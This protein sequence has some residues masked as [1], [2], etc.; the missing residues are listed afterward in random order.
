M[1]VIILKHPSYRSWI[2]HVPSL[3]TAVG[4][5][6]HQRRVRLCWIWWLVCWGWK[7]WF[8]NVFSCLIKFRWRVNQNL[9]IPTP[10]YVNRHD[11]YKFI[12]IYV[13]MIIYESNVFMCI[14]NYLYIFIS[15][16]VFIYRY[17]YIYVVSN[18]SHSY[19]HP[20][21]SNIFCVVL[22]V[23][24]LKQVPFWIF[25]GIFLRA[26]WRQ[27]HVLQRSRWFV[28]RKAVF[29]GEMCCRKGDEIPSREL[30]Y[31]PKMAFWRWVSFSQG[32]IC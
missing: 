21:I 13:Y 20:N 30:T 15:I 24:F 18:F 7:K 23:L 27:M 28:E 2:L 19:I 6:G 17:L 9:N 12:S 25:G 22:L 11:V 4:S 16:Y 14:Y 3:G 32:G 1:F 26:S 10:V 29:F 8:L 31:P 5:T